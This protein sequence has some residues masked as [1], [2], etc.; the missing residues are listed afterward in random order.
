VEVASH[1]YSHPYKWS[2]FE[3]YDRKLEERLVSPDETEWTAV[4]GDRVRRI[5]RRLF[6]GFSRKNEAESFKPE[7]DPPR[8]YSEFPFD[9]DQEIGGS[10]AAAE[11][12][13]PEGKR[14]TVYLWSGGAEPFE[15]AI[16]RTR[17]LRLRNLNGGDSRFDPDYPSITY[18]APIS[19]TAGTQRQIYAGNSN[20][21]IYITDGQGRDHGFLHLNAT[22]AATESPRRL[23]AVNVYYHMYAGERPAQL[24]AVRHHLDAA[25]QSALTPVAA[26][27]YAAMADGF[28]SI[29]MT[30][31]SE[32]SWRVANRGALQTL[33]FDDA[34]ELNVDFG[35]SPG[36]TGQA[37]KGAS[38]YVALDEG[39]D[40]PVVTLTRTAPPLVQRP[41]LI[42]ARWSFRDLQRKECGFAVTA[43]GYGTGQ[44]TW[45]GMRPGA[46]LV[47]ARDAKETVWDEEFE[48]REDGRL[49]FT[50]DAEALSSLEI[51]VRCLDGQGAR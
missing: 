51:E 18:L 10:I 13:A 26:S 16:A 34:A 33:R 19:R 12:L 17:R 29:E 50:V 42:D 27:H 3:N 7:E 22:I 23:K 11:E 40:E 41:Y 28:F 4:L 8:A 25:R 36:V 37:R 30:K 20:D 9:L 35:R 43:N 14:A 21:Y 5:A 1:S 2:F 15:E 32:L 31:L 24:A 46:Y 49:A 39:V 38:L 47:I 6:P 44:M 48:V 45:G